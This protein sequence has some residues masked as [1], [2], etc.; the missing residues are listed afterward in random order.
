[1]KVQ[2]LDTVEQVVHS[3]PYAADW[4]SL[5]R[6]QVP[7]WYQ[8]GKFGIFIHWGAYA[9]PAFGSEWYPRNM[10]QAGTPEYEHHLATYGAHREFGYKDFI[11]QFRAEQFDPQDWADLFRRAGARYVVPVA[12]HHDGFQMYN[13]ALSRWNA[14]QMGPKRD[15][16]GELAT[17]VRA[18][19]LVFGLSNH[20]A[21]HFFFFDGGLQFDSDVTDPAWT[22]FYGPPHPAPRNLDALE[23]TPPT[24]AHLEDWLARNC[25]LVDKYQPQLVFFD[26]WIQHLAF[27][28]Y[29]K[30]YAA[31]Y[32]NRAVS[33][34]KEVAINHKYEAFEKGS[35]VYDVERGQMDEIAP[36][37]W[38]CDTS[39]SKNSWGYIRDHEY[40]TTNDLICDL[41]DTVSKN[42]ALLLNIGPRADGTIPEPERG[43]LLDMGQWLA[44]NGEAIYETRPWRVFGEGPTKVVAGPFNDTKRASFSSED[45]RFT[46][47]GNT[48]Y[49]IVLKWP[50]NGRLLI[51]SLA[52]SAQQVNRVDLL[53]AASVP[54]WQLGEHGLELDVT[55][56]VPS[57][58]PV[59]FRI[60]G[61]D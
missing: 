23:D 17:A 3:G 41:A 61:Q 7:A 56:C 25:E 60:T 58:A 40:K 39:V 55:D 51:K 45:I 32:Y 13:S 42:G 33:W 46:R 54:K 15:V 16:I 28:P 35:A 43:L 52:G 2:I 11:P 10:Y 9:V 21:E 14:V 5:S 6:I 29:L 47:K 19:G 30:K 8:D 4:D 44:V 27:K 38:Q 26:W 57:G 20:R 1:M 48:L 37:F 24:R 31:Y 18:H 36:F 59:T 50:E 22:D 53:G 12:E 34:N 49:A